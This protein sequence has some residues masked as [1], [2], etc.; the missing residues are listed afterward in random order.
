MQK[1]FI[2]AIVLCVVVLYGWQVLFPPPRKTPPAPQQVTAVPSG[3]EA[4][5]APQAACG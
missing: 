5:G 4:P 3:A 2:L 1:Q